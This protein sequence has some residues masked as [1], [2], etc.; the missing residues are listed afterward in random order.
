MV[1]DQ[2]FP[3]LCLSDDLLVGLFC[4][5]VFVIWKGSEEDSHSLVLPDTYLQWLALVSL[6]PRTR[7]ALSRERNSLGFSEVLMGRLR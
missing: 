1:P 5:D 2:T 7:T 4:E 6:D 3:Y